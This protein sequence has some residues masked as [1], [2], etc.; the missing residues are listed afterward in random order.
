MHHQVIIAGSGISGL[1]A[2]IQLK[3]ILN[4]TDVKVYETGEELGG[5]WATNVYPGAKCDSESFTFL[6]SRDD[7][8]P[9]L[10]SSA[11]L[12]QAS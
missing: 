5:T 9:L 4:V 10:P 1:C 12:S 3:R 6:L 8:L 11:R 7:F 2:L